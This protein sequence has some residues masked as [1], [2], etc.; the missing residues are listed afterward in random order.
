MEERK[1]KQVIVMRKDL[2]TRKGKYC[3]QAAHASVGALLTMFKKKFIDTYQGEEL[4]EPIGI[5]YS[6]NVLNNTILDKWLNGIFTK[7]TLSVDSE[8]EMLSL[9]NTIKKERPDIPCVLITDSGLTEFNGVPTN[10]CIG[11]G[12]FWGDDIDAFTR[13]LNLF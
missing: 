9:Y 3:S 10:T 1:V 12:P 7:I 8:D 2:K 5:N 13:H 4:Q 6:L 11:I